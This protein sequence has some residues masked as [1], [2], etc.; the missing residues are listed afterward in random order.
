ME[1]EYKGMIDVVGDDKAGRRIIVVAACRFPDSKDL[2]T[3]SFI[4]FIIP[5]INKLQQL[6][7]QVPDEDPGQVRG[8]GLQ[9]R[10]LPPWPLIKS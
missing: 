10:L 3:K 4:R 9:P 1:E 2:D 7:N 5:V 8:H 6:L